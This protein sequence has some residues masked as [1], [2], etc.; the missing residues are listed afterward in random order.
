MPVP[1]AL[2]TAHRPGPRGRRPLPLLVGLIGLIGIVGPSCG[3]GDE[4]GGPTL[5]AIPTLEVSEAGRPIALSGSVI[6]SPGGLAEGETG[7]VAELR[8]INTGNAELVI[9]SIEVASDPAGVMVLAGTPAGDPLPEL[10]LRIAPQD[11]SATNVRRSLFVYLRLTRPAA[12]IAPSAAI[13]IRS[14]AVIGGVRV[15][16]FTFTVEVEQARPRLAAQPTTV[17]LGVVGRGQQGTRALSILNTGAAPLVIDRFTLAGHPGF[18]IVLGGETHPVSPAS[19]SPGITLTPP[20]TIPPGS[21]IEA[22]VRFAPTG[23]EPATGTLTLFSN[24]PAAAGGFTVPLRANVGGP[25]MAVTP[26]RVDFGAKLVGQL[27]TTLVDITSCGDAPLE[28]TG[29]ELTVDSSARLGLDLGTLPGL[30]DQGPVDALRPEDPPVVIAPGATASFAV[31][32]FPDAV[33]PLD[34]DGLPVRDVGVI[35]ITSNAFL[36]ELEVEVRGFGTDIPCPTAV[37]AID[38]GFEVVPQTVL[39]LRGSPSFAVQGPIASWSWEVQQPVGSQ[40]PFL[41]SATAANPTF[42]ANVAGEYVF[43]LHV[44]DGEGLESCVPA[45]ERVTVRPDQALHVSLTWRTP[46]DPDETN[47]H[48]SDLDLHFLHPNALTSGGT[49]GGWFDADGWDCYWFNRE[50]THWGTADPNVLDNPTLDRDD[51]NG[52]GP[53]NINF[54]VPEAGLTYRVGVHYWDDKG[55]GT[56]FAR[57]RVYLYGER[58]FELDDVALE[59]RDMWEVATIDWPSGAVKASRVCAGGTTPCAAP[60]DCGGAACELLITPGYVPTTIFAPECGTP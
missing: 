8:L 55:Y 6:V 43:R 2:V 19:N 47:N 38:E 42:E 3:D 56:S 24:D 25:C 32:Y 34:D 37:I 36:S 11:A 13:T 14:N 5:G 12:T 17:D 40:S 45:E 33:S 41:P 60:S 22:P 48:G 15:E 10:P 4:T 46:A 21:A 1:R 29:V 30:G 16:D 58:V 31:T 54:D 44:T 20:V 7:S 49:P 28:V 23:P 26:R 57:V 27:A 51:R 18:A 50:P 53:E 59:C 35:V 52:V 9:E 39:H